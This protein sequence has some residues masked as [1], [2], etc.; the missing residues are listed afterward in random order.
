M[1][2]P[3]E[4]QNVATERTKMSRHFTDGGGGVG[5]QEPLHDI[6]GPPAPFTGNIGIGPGSGK[7]VTQIVQK[8]TSNPGEAS[9]IHFSGPYPDLE[10]PAKS[11]LCLEVFRGRFICCPVPDLPPEKRSGGGRVCVFLISL[12]LH[13]FG[14]VALHSPHLLLSNLAMTTQCNAKISPCKTA[15]SM[16]HSILRWASCGQQQAKYGPSLLSWG[17]FYT[18]QDYQVIHIMVLPPKTANGNS[19]C[20]VTRKRPDKAKTD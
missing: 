1:R 9:K 16:Q 18:L 3:R 4:N 6:L 19:R 7:L 8:F 11:F 20:F 15:F 5:P 10:R 14:G 2:A 17:F 12:P 13:F